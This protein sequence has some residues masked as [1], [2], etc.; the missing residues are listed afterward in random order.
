MKNIRMKW[1]AV[2]TLTAN[3]MDTPLLKSI[4]NLA[5]PFFMNISQ[6]IVQDHCCYC[7]FQN[8][9]DLDEWTAL[10]YNKSFFG[11]GLHKRCC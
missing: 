2:Y 11:E 1:L 10:M 8:D 5:H 7:L 9:K 3:V 6:N 4:F